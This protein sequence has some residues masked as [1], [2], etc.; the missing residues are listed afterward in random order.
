MQA[1]LVSAF[2]SYKLSER[3]VPMAHTKAEATV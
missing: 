3:P 1:V 2:M